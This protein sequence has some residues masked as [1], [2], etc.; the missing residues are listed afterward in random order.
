M[1]HR[2]TRRSERLPHVGRSVVAARHATA[3]ELIYDAAWQRVARLRRHA[4]CYLCQICLAE[5]ALTA[6]SDVDHIIPIHVRPDWRLEFD[7]TQVIC[8]SH[9]RRKSIAD[10][11]RYGSSTARVLTPAQQQ[12]RRAAQ[13]LM[14]A[15]R[16]ARG[17]PVKP[18]D[19]YPQS[20]SPQ[21]RIPP[22]Y[23]ARGGSP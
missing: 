8:R 6:S 2:I 11:R 14:H 13:Q 22:R 9:H 18:V 3:C 19:V 21:A 20:V 16:S 15:P 7:N 12:A 4:D 17:G 23:W 1:P 10:A 5:E